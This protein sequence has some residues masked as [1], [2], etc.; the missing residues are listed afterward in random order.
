MAVQRNLELGKKD[1]MKNTRFD[2]TGR[3]NLGPPVYPF[4]PLIRRDMPTSYC[5]GGIN[6]GEVNFP[7]IFQRFLREWWI[8]GGERVWSRFKECWS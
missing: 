2:P 4:D 5:I 7:L 1:G 8:K 6:F 3:F